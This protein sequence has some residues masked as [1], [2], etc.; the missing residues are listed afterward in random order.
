MIVEYLCPTAA[1]QR[2]RVRSSSCGRARPARCPDL[3]RR[4][5]SISQHQPHTFG[6]P[7]SFFRA[8]RRASTSC[9]TATRGA[10]ALGP[11]ALQPSGAK[12]APA[13]RIAMATPT[14]TPPRR[15]HDLSAPHSSSAAHSTPSPV[16]PR[17]S[18]SSSSMTTSHPSSTPLTVESLLSAHQN[19]S[20]PRAAALEAAVSERN[21]L[22]AENAQLWK[23]IEKSRTAYI[24]TQKNLDRVRA[25][26]DAYK[27]RLQT[28][29]E[30]TDAVAKSYRDRERALK[31]SSSSSG[32]RQGDKLSASASPSTS[33]ARPTRHHSDDTPSSSSHT[34]NLT[35][36][37]SATRERPTP[38]VT[39]SYPHHSQ[40]SPAA[41]PSSASSVFPEPS[42]LSAN[43]AYAP[44]RSGSLPAP[45]T[46]VHVLP[47][48]RPL[49]IPHKDSAPPSSTASPMGPSLSPFSDTSNVSSSV[50]T[51]SSPA[52]SLSEPLNTP[53][54]EQSQAANTP[55]TA[56]IPQP[57]LSPNHPTNDRY[58]SRESRISLP[59]EA[60]H[61]I[62]TM[63]DSPQT[64]PQIAEHS[65]NRTQSPSRTAPDSNAD[66]SS[67]R[68]ELS[69]G[70]FLDMDDEDSLYDSTH[71]TPDRRAVSASP[72][73]S[74][75]D[76]RK[77]PAVDDFPLP[78]T[79]HPATNGDAP[80][81]RHGQHSSQD[82]VTSLPS[83]A[84]RPHLHGG[85]DTPTTP[86]ANAYNP[87]M[88][89]MST[90]QSV[91]PEQSA[92]PLFRALPL[93]PHDLPHTKIT[94]TNS[95][96]RPN[97]RGKDVLS[98]VV[99]VDPGSGKEGWIVEKLYS[100]VLGLDQRVR[101][102]YG[103]SVSKRVPS[104]PDGKLWR[105]HAPS[106]VDQ[107]KA[108]LE[109][110]VQALIDLPV[111]N[112]DEIIAFLTSDIIKETNKPV[113]RQGYKEGYLTKRG[114]NFGGWKTRFFVVQGPQ[115]EYYESRGGTHLGT[116]P[117]TGAQIG[118]QQRPTDRR[119]TEEEGEYRHAF[120]I[121]EPKRGAV[122]AHRH[123]LCA[124]SDS[125]RDD[126][127]DML[128]RYISGTYNEEAISPIAALSNLSINTSVSASSHQPRSSTSSNA[129]DVASPSN[130][131]RPGGRAASIKD[132][133]AISSAVPLSQLAPD[134]TNAKLFQAAPQYDEV[135]LNGSPVKGND[136]SPVV[137]RGASVAFTDAQTAKRLLEKG[138]Y[139]PAAESPL[140][141]SLPTPSP[142]EAAGNGDFVVPRANSELGHYPDLAE[143]RG[144]RARHPQP[145]PERARQRQAHRTS[146]HPTL[147]PV[148]SSPVQPERPATPDAMR[149]DANG[150]VKISGPMN[151]T[152]IPAGYKF[153]AKEASAETAAQGEQRREKAKSRM[154]WGWRQGEK[155]HA[156]TYVPRAVFG[157]TLEESLDV[158]QIAR[159]PAVVF[160]CIQYL[161]DKKAD[162]E[163]G[164]YRLSGSSAVIKSLKDKF[165]TEGDVDL[166][167]S[168]EFWDPHAIAGL[169]KSFFRDLPSSILTRELHMRFLA[170]ID[171]VDAQE[172]ITEL[173][174]LIA[175]LPIENYSLLRALTAHLILIVQNAHI[176]KMTMRNVGIVFSPTLG[177]PAGVFSLMLAEFNRVFNVDEEGAPVETEDE[178]ERMMTVTERAMQDDE[179]DMARRN[180]RQY[181]DAAADQLLGLSG[182]KLTAPDD[183]GASDDGE[184]ELLSVHD[185]SGTETTEGA[186]AEDSGRDSAQSSA[187][188]HRSR[189]GSVA[190]TRGL[191]IRVGESRRHSRMG[192]V[193]LPVSPRPPTTQ[194]PLNPGSTAPSPHTPRSSGA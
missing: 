177:I 16:T 170:V 123:V 28:L 147:N 10:S 70:E 158:A 3:C 156:V 81:Q 136:G 155:P 75:Q 65:P 21:R 8:R 72:A 109:K 43:Q 193:G 171:L 44:P 42:P 134:S 157:V 54:Y 78:P 52:P 182:R 140:S 29:G 161:E 165:N 126:W 112:N 91:I 60:K 162:Q 58:L 110:Y 13:S 121:I 19:A 31:P 178:D 142:L 98:F 1:N 130:Y 141:S 36:E 34:Q 102:R 89:Y 59:A 18:A 71:E 63:T 138:G 189:I 26:R 100:D 12:V 116:I 53:L 175:A 169:L 152:P 90:F 41:I 67:V 143:P 135:S 84:D 2:L 51:S 46:P 148:Q 107:R 6:L 146:Y 14:A 181:S 95:S 17:P 38:V 47:P 108:V 129:P 96:I 145:S 150:K 85:L 99:W 24:E 57:S 149:P 187:E 105:D 50:P 174:R 73:A 45:A 23:V 48:T 119:E 74:S 66:K 114:K 79:S 190:A 11:T 82:S 115:L 131:R 83:L 153:G 88:S 159:L 35:P 172:R 133:I 137:D 92:Q 117:I 167:A 30:N 180:S 101:A 64:S 61:Y 160:R 25:E 173:S 168:D 125:E 77:T 113:S 27:G 184:E 154:F 9:I 144:G 120:L 191:N 39:V 128:V 122:S 186:T 80:A 188:Q 166:L 33:R 22:S 132:E 104:L 55:L 94:V 194:S 69:D 185:E 37:W 118:R 176:N 179:Q 93:L 86:T 192:M 103:K 183:D 97:D 40:N 7:P 163:E 5:S 127:V 139:T 4:P 164:I 124:E 49:Q 76:S 15:H 32:M 68:K 106:K 87:H 111:K 62:S 20:D 56:S 151:G